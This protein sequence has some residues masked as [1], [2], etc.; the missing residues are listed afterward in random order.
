MT[1]DIRDILSEIK[2][3]LDEILNSMAGLPPK[4]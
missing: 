3:K 2:Q 4:K 1:D